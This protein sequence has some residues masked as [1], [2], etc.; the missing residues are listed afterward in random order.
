MRKWLLLVSLLHFGFLL[1]ASTG[2][3]KLQDHKIPAGVTLQDANQALYKQI[4][5]I[6]EKINP[7]LIMEAGKPKK[8]YGR[9]VTINIEH[10]VNLN[11]EINSDR[12]V[13]L[14]GGHMYKVLAAF[15][16]QEFIANSVVT[17]HLDNNCHAFAG[18]DVITGNQFYKTTFPQGWK[19]EDVY[20]A[21]SSSSQISEKKVDGKLIINATVAHNNNPKFTIR[22]VSYPRPGSK[23]YE[24]VTAFPEL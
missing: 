23:I 16:S 24:M 14:K 1:I 21:I 20:T 10:I 18:Y 7:Q 5:Q 3:I 4:K 22:T 9:E 6:N 13:T 11:P 2:N 8:L 15:K 17:K 19:P 12:T